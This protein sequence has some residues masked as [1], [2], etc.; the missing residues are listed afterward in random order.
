VFVTIFILL[1]MMESIISS[2][3][4]MFFNWRTPRTL[5]LIG[6]YVVGCGLLTASTSLL[7]FS[8]DAKTLSRS[9]RHG[10]GN[11]IAGIY[12]TALYIA[13]FAIL[14]AVPRPF[15]SDMAWHQ[16]Y[17]LH[18][19]LMGPGLAAVPFGFIFT[20]KAKSYLKLHTKNSFR[21]I[22]KWNFRVLI[23]AAVLMLP[24]A[25]VYVP[26]MQSF[27]CG[28][29]SISALRTLSSAQ[30]LYKTRTGC[31]GDYSNLNDGKGNKYI[32]V[33]LA[34]ADPDHPKALPKAGCWVDIS[35]NAD[36]TDWCAIARPAVW[37]DANVV[38]EGEYWGSR[39]YLVTSDGVIYWNMEKDGTEFTDVLG[40]S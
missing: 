18:M 39:N 6:M 22:A 5:L 3:R 20:V 12:C 29:S 38:W 23:V 33:A 40:S 26:P 35:V 17:T 32:D 19:V 7:I 14:A 1:I 13:T 2:P 11:A 16:F 34:R 36:K 4:P 31:Y 27:W 28:G 10:K 21:R 15:M 30:E 9:I 25:P 24:F 8:K 37:G